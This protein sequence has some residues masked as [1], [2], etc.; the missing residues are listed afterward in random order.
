MKPKSWT[1]TPGLLRSAPRSRAFRPAALAVES[2]YID[3]SIRCRF[4]ACSL[5]S[6]RLV[7]PSCA[8]VM[9]G[10]AFSMSPAGEARFV[11]PMPRCP[12]RV[13]AGVGVAICA[14]ARRVSV[15]IIVLGWPGSRKPKDVSASTT[16]LVCAPRRRWR[17]AAS[18]SSEG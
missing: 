4:A 18:R 15:A 16:S 9:S 7:E 10:A 2:S 5:V 3:G 14:S 13:A 6:T 8:L 12:P 1:P 11:P 17:R